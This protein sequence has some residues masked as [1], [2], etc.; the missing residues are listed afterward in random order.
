MSGTFIGNTTSIQDMF[1]RITNQFSL[2]LSKKAFLHSY[3][4]EGME[5]IEFTEVESNVIDLISEYQ[6]YQDAS[7][8][9]VVDVDDDEEEYL[10]V[11]D[12]IEE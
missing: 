9:D 3:L 7:I 8:D 4:E 11:Q 1:K 2:M 10:N 12:I 6:Q 5:E